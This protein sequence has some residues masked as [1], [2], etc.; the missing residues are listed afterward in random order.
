MG[1]Q[2]LW[3]R[4]RSSYRYKNM[5][6]IVVYISIYLL[7]LHVYSVIYHWHIAQTTLYTSKNWLHQRNH[8]F[9]YVLTLPNIAQYLCHIIASIITHHL[10]ILGRHQ[11]KVEQTVIIV[12]GRLNAASIHESMKNIKHTDMPQLLHTGVSLLLSFSQL[13]LMPCVV[14]K[15]TD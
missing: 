5:T 9:L 12:C 10:Q 4:E 11:P 6:G 15:V 8:D 13:S 7:A 1:I 14:V 3:R 2:H